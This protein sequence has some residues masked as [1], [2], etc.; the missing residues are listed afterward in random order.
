MTLVDKVVQIRRH[1]IQRAAAGVPVARVCHEAGI[2]RTLFYA[3]K[4][5][6]LRYGHAG[7]QP[8]PARPRRW[9]QQSSPA[10]EQAVVASAL[11]CPTHGPARVS[12]ERRKRL[13]RL[14]GAAL[15]TLGLVTERTRR[16]IR[17][18][19]LAGGA[20]ML[21]QLLHRETEGRREAVAADGV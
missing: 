4:R 13:A 10:L 11:R 16:A 6:Y 20:G 14:E 15:E 5:R 8:R 18:E 1:V 3:W 2:S 21:G 12:D 19:E 7:L 17:G 9:G